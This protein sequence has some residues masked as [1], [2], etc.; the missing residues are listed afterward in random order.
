MLRLK[1]YMYERVSVQNRRFRFNGG[2][3]SQNFR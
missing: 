2:Q 1:L 3:M